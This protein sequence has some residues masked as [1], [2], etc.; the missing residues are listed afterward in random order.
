MM[1]SQFK[2]AFFVGGILLLT[3]CGHSHE[4]DAHRS[5]DPDTVAGKAGEAAYKVSKEA[6]KAAKEVGHKVAEA[7]KD[8]H[9]GWKDASKEDKGKRDR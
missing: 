6:G 7:A 4:A 9:A 1:M 3:A 2:L 8:A 5:G